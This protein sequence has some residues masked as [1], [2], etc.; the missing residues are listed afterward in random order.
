MQLKL[1]CG[2]LPSLR[3]CRCSC[4]PLQQHAAQYYSPNISP[5]LARVV[6]EPFVNAGSIA[7]VHVLVARLGLKQGHVRG[8]WNRPA[9]SKTS[10]I[11]W[12][13]PSARLMPAL[14]L[15]TQSK[16]KI[17]LRAWVAFQ[18]NGLWRSESIWATAHF[19][20]K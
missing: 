9:S 7:G 15:R 1:L 8:E 4:T 16:K 10:P 13:C 12:T 6:T 14:L 17:R 18:A 11:L 3:L 5:L 2:Q 20:Q 19:T